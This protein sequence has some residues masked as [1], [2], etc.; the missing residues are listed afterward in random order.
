[1]AHAAFDFAIRY[2]DLT[3]DWHVTSNTLVVLAVRD[4]LVLGWLFR[5]AEIAGLRVILVYEPDLGDA[6]TAAAIEHRDVDASC[7]PERGLGARRGCAL[8][9]SPQGVKPAETSRE[10]GAGSKWRLRFSWGNSHDR[11]PG[12]PDSWSPQ[13]RYAAW[14]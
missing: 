13:V 1:M 7:A 8:V 6:L 4:E 9:V 10:A 14:M 12:R 11:R 2:A 3:Y 5:D